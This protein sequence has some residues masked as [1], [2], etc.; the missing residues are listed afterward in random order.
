MLLQLSVLQFN[1]PLPTELRDVLIA[2]WER[3]IKNGVP[4]PLPRKLPII[5]I[6]KGYVAKAKA[7]K[8]HFIVIIFRTLIEQAIAASIH[9]Q[10]LA[11]HP[12]CHNWGSVAPYKERGVFGAQ[13]AHQRV[14]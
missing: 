1:L 7:G 4:R 3:T 10:Q 5:D 2:D 13:C 6:L 9:C 8:V 11:G 14:F 12:A